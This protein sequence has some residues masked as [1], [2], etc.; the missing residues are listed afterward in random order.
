MKNIRK[1]ILAA[2]LTATA[3]TMMAQD[4]NSAYFTQD[5]KYRH[6]MNPAYGND[7]GYAAIPVLGNLNVK[8]QGSFGVGDVL[9]K[10][11]YYGNPLY[12]K[13][14]KT[15]T[16]MHPAISADEALKG[17]DKD[18][19]SLIFDMDIP[20]VSVGFK[21]LGGYNTVELKERTHVALSIPYEFFDF[22]KNM[23]NQNYSFDDLGAR[24]WTYAEIGLGHSR[25]IFDN[26][27]VGAK[28]KFLLGGA[29]ADFSMDGVEANMVGD[30]WTIKGKA[31]AELNMKGGKFKTET[32][33]YREGTN[34]GQ[35]YNRVNGID[36]DN[37][38]IGGF[39]LGLDLGAVY[40]FKD[41]SVE[42]LDGMK[43][44]AS[45]TD[46]G[47]ISWS[48]TMVAESS[49]DPFEFNGFKM[50]YENGS[51]E[52][53]GD[54]IQDDF[55]DFANLQDKGE[56]S[57][58]TNALAATMRLGVEY[59]MPFYD[60]LSAGLLY[61]H[62]FDGLY[63]WSEGRLSANVS[64]LTW[65]NGGLNV[66]VTSFCTT[67]GWVLNVHPSGFNFFIGMDHIIGKTGASMVPL[68]SNVSFNMGMNIAFGSKKKDSK[69]DLN[70]LTF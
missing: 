34:K 3:G 36:T 14:K 5:F 16:F 32:E 64:P 68:D 10:N 13:A 18:G 53:G 39:G 19:N 6:D 46:L 69:G 33:N 48:N 2:V 67:M 1:Y 11:P 50:K 20:I 47:F 61:T 26:L 4:L 51:F 52:N 45:L 21:A 41:C 9:F 63:K 49:G 7:Q 15:A 44:S 31:K 43:V 37:M 60:K 24:G 25:Q 28:V 22:A 59:P 23:K 12:P 38:G 27:R 35:P 55:K 17:L 30:K 70:T 57:G 40:T 54:D 42:W 56:T 58:K 65:L 29:Y 66:A 8:L 62:R